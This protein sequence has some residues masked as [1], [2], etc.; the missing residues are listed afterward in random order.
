MRASSTAI[1]ILVGTKSDMRNDE[2]LLAKKVK[3][4]TP[5]EVRL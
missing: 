5:E 3:Q 2:E 4:V 1:A